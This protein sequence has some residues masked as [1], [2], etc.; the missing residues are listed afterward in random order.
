[1]QLQPDQTI[2]NLVLCF[3]FSATIFIYGFF[4]ISL[5]NGEIASSKDLPDVVLDVPLV[6]SDDRVQPIVQLKFNFSLNA[7]GYR[8]RHSHS[9]LM[10]IDAMRFDFAQQNDSMK[11]FSKLIKNNDACL[12]H[13]NVQPPTVT[14]PRIKVICF[15]QN[16]SIPD[17][18]LPLYI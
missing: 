13:L 10:V 15:N 11:Y 3:I 7:S 9:I 6:F 16:T 2:V 4:P 17:I 8:S 18:I 14:L 1:M 12:F 5:K